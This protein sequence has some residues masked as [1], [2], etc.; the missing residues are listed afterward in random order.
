MPLHHSC[1]WH[2]TEPSAG[3]KIEYWS[4]EKDEYL[5][6]Y[7]SVYT[8]TCC[9]LR[10]HENLGLQFLRSSC[11]RSPWSRTTYNNFVA[12]GDQMHQALWGNLVTVI[13]YENAFVWGEYLSII[14]T[15]C[16][17]CSQSTLGGRLTMTLVATISI[18]IFSVATFSH[19]RS[20]QIQKL[21]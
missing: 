5:W 6:K 15:S 18:I 17:R 16:W 9:T 10:A 8:E 13:S 12:I 2:S 4:L 11:I 21:I 14:G 19:R 20:A 1:T 7:Y 3:R